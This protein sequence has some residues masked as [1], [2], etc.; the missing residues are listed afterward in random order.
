MIGAMPAVA[1][2]H[3]RRK[4]EPRNKRPSQLGIQSPPGTGDSLDNMG[5]GSPE[6]LQSPPQRQ[7]LDREE[8]Y[9]CGKVRSACHR[10][11]R[12]PARYCVL[13]LPTYEAVLCA[14]VRAA[15]SGGVPVAGRH[16]GDRGAGAA[17]ARRRRQSAPLPAAGRRR[18]AAAARRA[19][20][21]AALLRPALEGA[22]PARQR[23]RPCTKPR[24]RPRSRGR[25]RGLGF[26]P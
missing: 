7:L 18:R 14:G 11:G 8:Y 23:T 13:V 1:V 22:P 21:C 3:E 26:S 15:R 20:G 12:P 25:H 19:A 2:R 17:H 5:I 9:V 4:R 16:L 6:P 24:S 10:Q